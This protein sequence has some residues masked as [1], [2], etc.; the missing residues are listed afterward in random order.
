MQQESPYIDLEFQIEDAQL[1]LIDLGIS[2]IICGNK[3]DL[4]SPEGC[5][6]VFLS[7]WQM[8]GG[9]RGYRDD[10]FRALEL[11]AWLMS[12]GQL[13]I[14]EHTST[15]AGIRINK[16]I[17]PLFGKG[18]FKTEYDCFKVARAVGV[19]ETTIEKLTSVMSDTL[20]YVRKIP[21]YDT[22]VDYDQVIPKLEEAMNVLDNDHILH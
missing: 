2:A 21:T 22:P 3:S 12:N 7:T 6:E 17:L 15:L 13:Y 20:N 1:T 5:N 4:Q 18:G 19:H 9:T 11:I 16:F 8:N 10:V 14:L